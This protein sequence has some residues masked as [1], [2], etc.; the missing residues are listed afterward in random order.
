M[1]LTPPTQNVFYISVVLAVLGILGNLIS[2]PFVSGYA[3]W[4]VVVAYVV[5]FLGNTMKGL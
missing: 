2:I 5:L 1:K 4:F 3:F